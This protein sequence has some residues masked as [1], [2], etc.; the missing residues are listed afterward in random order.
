MTAPSDTPERARDA[1][2]RP[3]DRPID[4]TRPEWIALE[5]EFRNL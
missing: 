1:V 5:T 4:W 2:L 3:W